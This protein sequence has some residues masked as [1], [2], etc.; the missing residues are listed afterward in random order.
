MSCRNVRLGAAS[1]NDMCFLGNTF[2]YEQVLPYFLLPRG[3]KTSAEHV[4]EISVY[5]GIRTCRTAW[6]GSFVLHTL[7]NSKAS[8]L[9]NKP[10]YMFQLSCFCVPSAE[11]S[12]RLSVMCHSLQE[13]HS[14][15]IS[16][17]L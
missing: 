15:C 4:A 6:K 17:I 14:T 3:P 7:T 8:W 13:R 1:P 12:S 2:L 5:R 16:N 10:S 11:G 9:F